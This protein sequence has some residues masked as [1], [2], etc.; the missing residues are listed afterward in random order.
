MTEQDYE[1]A[2]EIKKEIQELNYEYD[3]VHK[4]W[5]ALRS[6]NPPD[7]ALVIKKE[8]EYGISLDQ[9][10]AFIAVNAQCNHILAKIERLKEEFAQLGHPTGVRDPMGEVDVRFAAHKI[11]KERDTYDPDAL[12]DA[13]VSPHDGVDREAQWAPDD[14]FG[15]E[16]PYAN[17]VTK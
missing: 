4:M 6:K 15:D 12:A 1:I 16:Y 7:I 17:L 2:T 9:D 8:H 5:N 14:D 13:G 11:V 10:L 3:T